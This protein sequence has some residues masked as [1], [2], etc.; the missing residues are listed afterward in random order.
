MEHDFRRDGKVAQTACN[1]KD[2]YGVNTKNERSTRY[3]INVLDLSIS[4]QKL[5]KLPEN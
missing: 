5:T 4:I 1:I 2:V 3:W